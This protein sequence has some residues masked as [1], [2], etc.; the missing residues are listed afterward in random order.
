[1]WEGVVLTRLACELQANLGIIVATV[2][3]TVMLRITA[4][5]IPT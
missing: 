1:M 2:Y 4:N 3:G 5:L